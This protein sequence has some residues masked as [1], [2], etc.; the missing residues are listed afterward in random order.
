MN[1]QKS[2]KSLLTE[3]EGETRLLA[4]EET[5]RGHRWRTRDSCARTRPDC[6]GHSHCPRGR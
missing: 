1:T 4:D 2:E 6:L 5:L 3:Q